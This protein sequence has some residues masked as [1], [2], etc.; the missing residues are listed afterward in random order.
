[1]ADNFRVIQ[2]SRCQHNA[3]IVPL[4]R[5]VPNAAAG[6]ASSP[7][8]DA[9]GPP[10]RTLRSPSRVR[11]SVANSPGPFARPVDDG[12]T[13]KN[14]P[15]VRSGAIRRFFDVTDTSTT[16]ETVYISL[17]TAKHDV[18][19]T[20]ASSRRDRQP[21]THRQRLAAHGG[22]HGCN[23]LLYPAPKL[24]NTSKKNTQLNVDN[25]KW[26][27]EWRQFA[28]TA[29]VRGLRTTFETC[30]W[31]NAAQS[32][33]LVISRNIKYLTRPSATLRNA[34]H[35]VQGECFTLLSSTIA[36]EK[37]LTIKRKLQ[38]D[39]CS[40]TITALKPEGK[41]QLRQTWL[42]LSI[43]RMIDRFPAA[44]AKCQHT[45]LALGDGFEFCG[46]H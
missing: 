37:R 41:L 21:P 42:L 17:D 33:N 11:D 34:I 5:S 1:M 19:R 27:E 2:P 14:F 6:T 45:I 40:G 26:H 15:G 24:T 7:I 32:V 16:I 18:N 22:T 10:H 3:N 25:Q 36:P 31:V 23:G 29:H 28:P 30:R 43:Y 20:Y 39:N 35:G 13:K 8:R 4:C 38:L 9:T 44:R 46:E 12:I